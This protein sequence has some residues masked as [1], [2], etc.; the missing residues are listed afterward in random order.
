[1]SASLLERIP[2]EEISVQAREADPGR[3]ALSVIAGILIGAGWLVSRTLSVAWIA[4]AWMVVAVR[5]GW[6]DGRSPEW[7]AH[8]ARRQAE[9]QRRARAGRTGPG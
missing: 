5:E 4:A 7:A 8:V 6:R 9:A 3:V 2:V 1:M